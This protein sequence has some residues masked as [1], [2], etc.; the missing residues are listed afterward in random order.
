VGEDP[1]QKADDAARSGVETLDEGGF[2]K[3]LRDA[4]ADI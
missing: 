4:G 3:L 1:G 2:V